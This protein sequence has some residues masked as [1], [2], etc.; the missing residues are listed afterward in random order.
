MQYFTNYNIFIAV[1]RRYIFSGI[2]KGQQSR[3]TRRPPSR[4]PLLFE[5]GPR[6]L[7]GGDGWGLSIGKE[8]WIGTETSLGIMLRIQ[9]DK[10]RIHNPYSDVT[11]FDTVLSNELYGIGVSL[12]YN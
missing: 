5:P 6:E 9:R 3:E 7:E 8:K 11:V 12:V 1:Q 2:W 4:R 10:L